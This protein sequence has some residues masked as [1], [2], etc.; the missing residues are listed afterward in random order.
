MT[1]LLAKAEG[2]VSPG[3]QSAAPVVHQDNRL[4]AAIVLVRSTS[5]RATLQHVVEQRDGARRGLD[6][7]KNISFGRPE[8]CIREV[9]ESGVKTEQ[10][11][12]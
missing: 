6:L 5:Y 11:R 12:R 8:R 1:K 10:R 2:S 3:A 7:D 9:E 4:V